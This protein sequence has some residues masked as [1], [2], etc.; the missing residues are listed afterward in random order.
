MTRQKIGSMFL[1]NDLC[2]FSENRFQGWI[3]REIACKGFVQ[4]V[5]PLWNGHDGMRIPQGGRRVEGLLHGIIDTDAE[6]RREACAKAAD[7]V[8]IKRNDRT[9]EHGS[10]DLVP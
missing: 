10:L 8:E 4:S 2:M 7:V 9:F 1:I 6:A 3:E 5:F